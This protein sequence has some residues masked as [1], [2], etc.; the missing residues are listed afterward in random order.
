MA[1]NTT[2]QNS[3]PSQGSSTG[4][5]NSFM[6]GMI[7]DASEL[8]VPD[9][10]WTN[11]INAINISH[12]GDE[13]VIGNEQSNK[14]CTAAPYTIIGILHKYQGEWVV[15]ST[16][17]IISEIGIFN[18]A[19][20][21]YT[22]VVNDNCLNFNTKY[23]ITGAVKYNA[24]CTYSVYWADN[25]NPDRTLNLDNVPYKYIETV[26]DDCITRQYTNQ[27]DCEALRLH[28]LVKQPCISVKT[29]MGAGQL[30]SGSYQA[31]IAYSHNG[32]KLTDYSTPSLPQGI[33]DHS[34]IGGSIDINITNLDLN[35]DEYELVVISVI[36]QQTVA[37]KIG[38]YSTMQSQVHLDLYLDA[39]E[40]IPLNTIPLKTQIYEKSKKMFTLNGYLIRTSV[41]TQPYFNYQPFANKIKTEWVSVKYP[42]DYYW[43]KG[44][45]TGYMRDE[46]YSF[47]IRWV[48]KTGARSASFHI[49]GRESIPS[50]LITVSSSSSDIVDPTQNHIWQVY[51]TSTSTSFTSTG[52]IKD[53]GITLQKGEMGYWESTEKYPA[54]KPQIW[55]NLCGKPIRH[56]KMPSNETTHIHDTTGNFINVLGVQFTNILHPVDINGNIIEDI[57][58]YE[59]LR[60]SREGN[61][62]IVAKGMFNNMLSYSIP[63]SSSR[64]LMQNYPYND[65]RPDPFLQNVSVDNNFYTFHSP[66]NNL[67]KPYLGAGVYSKIYTEEQGTM[68]GSYITPHKHPREKLLTDWGFGSATIIAVGIALI[69]TTGKTST[70]QSSTAHTKNETWAAPYGSGYVSQNS[71]VN[72]D[73]GTAMT[74]EG[75][76]ATQLTNY[77]TQ[78]AYAGANTATS[79]PASDA[80]VIA[81]IIDLIQIG[82]S[83][84]TFF[85]EALDTIIDIWY[86]LIPFQDYVAQ[87]NSHAFYNS[88]A[89]VTNSQVPSGVPNKSLTRS[90]TSSKYISNGVQDFDASNRIN[91][92]YRNKLVAINFKNVLPNPSASVDATKQQASGPGLYTEISA[93]TTA[94][95]GALKLDYQNQY[96]Q[97]QSIIQVPTD[98]C[99]FPS[100]PTL[101]TPTY[102]GV[103]FGGDVYINRYTEKNMY[104]FF[105]T[106][107]FDLPD[108]T[109]FNYEL[110]INGPRPVYWANFRH[111]AA[112]D[113]DCSYSGFILDPIDFFSPSDYHNLDQVGPQHNPT[114]YVR[115]RVMYLFNNGVR[116]FF[117]ESELNMAFRDY[118]ENEWEK[119]YDVYGNSF[120]DLNTM[121]RSDIITRPIYYK[122]D[123][124]LSTT[125]LYSNFSSWGSILPPD[126]DP[127]LYDTCYQYFPYRG[128]YSLQQQDGLKR[129]NWRNFLPLNY[130]TFEGIVTNIKSVNSS[131]ALVL[132]EDFS[133]SQ[134]V[135]VDTLK[136]DTG[137]TK[138][139]IGD[140]GLF[141]NN[142]QSLANAE[143][144]MEYGASISNRATLNTPYGL[145]YVSQK[146]GKVIQYGSQGLQEISSSGMKNWFLQNL[147]SELLKQFP[148]FTEYDN[149][150]SGVAVQAI[151]DAQ[152]EL[153]YITKKDY[154]PKECVGYTPE[155]GFYDTCDCPDGCPTGYTLNVETN[156]CEKI[157]DTPLCQEG[158]TYN[159]TTNMCEQTVQTPAPCTLPFCNDGVKYANSNG[160]P[161]KYLV[162]TSFYGPYV[163]TAI[164]AVIVRVRVPFSNQIG[165]R[166]TYDGVVYNKLSSEFTGYCMS[167]T[168]G[169][170]TIIGNKTISGGSSIS[171]SGGTLVL[172]TVTTPGC[173]PGN[174]GC[175]QEWQI[176]P[177]GFGYF[178]IADTDTITWSS[179]DIYLNSYPNEAGWCTMVI[180]KTSTTENDILAE[181]FKIGSGHRFDIT[182]TCPKLLPGFTASTLSMSASIP[183]STATGQTYYFAKVHTGSD[184]YIGLYDFVF[185]DPNGEFELAD[186]WYLTNYTW[187]YPSKKVLHVQG[188]IVVEITN[189]V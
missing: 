58:G 122:Y 171:T 77:S 118:G 158:F 181:V 175:I 105:N 136:T 40:T 66:E 1:D 38:N 81:Q 79:S 102:T 9:G 86:K 130:Y 47:F 74:T 49:P 178:P 15:F 93:N 111:F 64:G 139:T 162:P 108:D 154:K 150:V 72:F 153:L 164:G 182:I 155:L 4:K 51:D 127:V 43:K 2:N 156:K 143:D 46:V 132:Y 30:Q 172:D 18:E 107:A 8:F 179:S 16:D 48:Y 35:F 33:W 185:T 71:Y 99:V 23:M 161:T 188:G 157:V 89:K 11:A 39:L 128:I 152:Y 67:V 32:I 55:G 41:T 138:I 10:V 57:A 100:I 7:K 149:P 53:G 134:F 125:K 82:A 69:S 104:S 174:S 60:G 184:N 101:N 78:L 62:S 21:S 116:D 117:T 24:D 109:P 146:A 65:L 121:F 84:V 97:L 70:T 34:S 113:F 124:S 50:D 140:G 29:S 96:G 98:S 169:N 88:F 94:Y 151:Y 163:T 14:Y 144:V 186:G 28:P 45:I 17:N 56:H 36:N 189:C 159:P 148:N 59:I 120:S 25:N 187:A 147:P 160:Y 114:I 12:K 5:T 20:C 103:V 42:A 123:L 68:K 119:F 126:Y 129:D 6:K 173:A 168:P 61:R 26:V 142:I 13:G 3:T 110:Y 133:P 73:T 106:W 177:T 80:T 183:C 22:K 87:F 137:N 167:A 31:V 52:S 115:N 95:Y 85:Y 135:G 166:V 176:N 165:I 76:S 112:A 63:N 91:N 37:K 170:Y 75:G 141:A 44:N 19:D 131:G 92:L 180:P 83:F 145:F 54:D 90:I 27:L